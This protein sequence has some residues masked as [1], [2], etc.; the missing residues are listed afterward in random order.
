MN[1][2]LST[3]VFIWQN[4]DASLGRGLTKYAHRSTLANFG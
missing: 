4:F 2:E 1:K 3:A